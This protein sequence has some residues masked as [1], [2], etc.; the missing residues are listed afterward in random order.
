V[1]PLTPAP[2][3][4]PL[5]GTLIH[6]QFTVMVREDGTVDPSVTRAWSLGM[7]SIAHRQTLEGFHAWRFRP[8]VRQGRPVRSGFIV[9]VRTEERVDTI[10]ARLHWTHLQRPQAEDSL[11]GR[12]ETLPGPRASLDEAQRDSVFAAVFRRFLHMRVLAPW[13]GRPYCIVLDR[14]ADDAALHGRLSRMLQ[15]HFRNRP[16][17][18]D[19]S[20]DRVLGHGCEREPGAIRLFLPRLHLTENHRV[21][22]YPAGDFLEGWPPGPR[23]TSLPGW[24]SRCVLYAPP[25]EGRTRVH[26]DV[27]PRYNYRY[28]GSLW[29]E[30]QSPR[31]YREGDSVRVTVVARMDESFQS[32]TLSGVVT[33]VRRFSEWTVLDRDS[34][35]TGSWQAYTSGPGKVYL[36]HGDLEDRYLDFNI[37]EAVRGAVPPHPQ[38]TC[39]GQRDSLMSAFLLGDLGEP[40]PVTLCKGY[41]CA[42]R[43]EVDPAR[44]TLAERAVVR[45]HIGELREATRIGDQLRFRIHVDPVPEGLMPLILVRHGT[46]APASLWPARRVELG[47]W[48][49]NVTYDS[50]IPPDSEVSIYLARR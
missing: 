30:A 15:E 19:S 48:D 40:A 17:P 3:I 18:H 36:L 5:A 7:D 39:T 4:Q 35:C 10:P 13:L 31:W 12:W 11:I 20:E 27:R 9:H 1:G 29:R 45:F 38:T 25:I 6:G 24:T 41:P 28:H 49:F 50:R 37:T 46:R 42:R 44:H 43:Y 8:A 2:D 16:D 23:T 33:E 34:A 26:C 32:D 14:E 47:A 21:V 22:T